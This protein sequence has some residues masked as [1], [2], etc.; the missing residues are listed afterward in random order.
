MGSATLGDN[1]ELITIAKNAGLGIAGKVYFAGSRF[2]LAVLITRT[3]GP[4]HYGLYML[5]LS[6]VSIIGSLGNF[7]IE[8]AMVR[9]VAHHLVRKEGGHAKGVIDFGTRLTAASGVLIATGLFLLADPI[10]EKIFGKP[11]LAP[12]LR[13]MTLSLPFW[14]LMRLFL[15][16]L[17]GAKLVKYSILI[18]QV[19]RP[20]IRFLLVAVAFAI[21]L[22]LMGVVWAWVIA[23]FIAFLLSGYFLIRE[24]KKFKKKRV[25]VKIKTV[26]A[27]SLPLWMSNIISK[28]NREIGLLLI[29][30]FLTADQ[31]GIFSVAMR[32]MPFILI[33]FMAYNAI[34]SPIISSLY[35][36]NKL[37]ELETIYKIGSRW[38]ISLTLPIFVL[39][40]FFSKEIISIFGRGFSA[41]QEVLI[42]LLIAQM[43]NVITGS[44]MHV[45]TM[46]GKPIYNLINSIIIFLLNIILCTVMINKFGAI[47]AAYALGITISIVQFLQLAE[48]YYLLKIHP[49]SWELLKPF[50]S[51]FFSL[52]IILF[53]RTGLKFLPPHCLSVLVLGIFSISYLMFLVLLGLSNEDR[54]ILQKLA[55]G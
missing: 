8:H 41:S 7:G 13:I 42:V 14:A 46:T 54:I 53:L 31:A 29:G 49:F 3:I 44:A 26:L 36:N 34:F 21:G 32:M 27:F 37:N 38:V 35:T 4:E 15:S 28:Y 30:V 22:Q 55:I 25:K 51:C 6:L 40:V 50:V 33:P 52:T 19:L 17:Q 23:S 45:L 18:E 1:N 10:A 5:G 16:A 43:V 47:G 2:L 39:M 24:T 9:F 48:V 20:S 11:E 12:V